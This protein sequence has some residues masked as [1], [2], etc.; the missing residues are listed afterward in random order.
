[1]LRQKGG[2]GCQKVTCQIGVQ[3]RTLRVFLKDEIG[4]TAEVSDAQRGNL[5]NWLRVGDR[6]SDK[7]RGNQAN[8]KG[9]N[10][11]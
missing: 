8:I 1:M 2:P 7:F 5:D 3:W 4:G 6:N 11:I 10:V 9:Y